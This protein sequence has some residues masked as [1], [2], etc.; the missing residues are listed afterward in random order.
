MRVH[1]F[2][3]IFTEYFILN[4]IVI[5][6][7]ISFWMLS[8]LYMINMCIQISGL[9]VAS[10]LMFSTLLQVKVKFALWWTVSRPSLP[11]VSHS[12]G[13]PRPVFLIFYKSSDSCGFCCGTPFLTRGRVC[14]LQLLLGLANAVFLGSKFLR[15]LDHILTHSNMRLPQSGGPGSCIYFPQEQG[16]PSDWVGALVN[17]YYLLYILSL[18]CTGNISHYCLFPHCCGSNMSTELFPSNSCSTVAY[19]HNWVCKPQYIHFRWAFQHGGTH[20]ILVRI[21][22]H[23]NRFSVS[24]LLSPW[25]LFHQLHHIQ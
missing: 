18:D 14:S 5:L 11:G 16:T 2:S 20:L 3:I 4:L 9:D 25:K 21:M 7:R 8:C 12:S 17:C 10:W 15:T 23:C 1:I 6:F 24:A 22:W 19:L 13:T